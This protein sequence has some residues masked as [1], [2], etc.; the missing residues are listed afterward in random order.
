ME[1]P[2]KHEVRPASWTMPFDALEQA[3]RICQSPVETWRREACTGGVFHSYVLYAR[4]ATPDT[5]SLW[6]DP[7]VPTPEV[8]Q[9]LEG[10]GYQ[11]PA[12]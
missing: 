8:R 10:Y 11:A 9:L 3:L 5:V 12:A 2:P 1:P 7:D 6:N 4:R